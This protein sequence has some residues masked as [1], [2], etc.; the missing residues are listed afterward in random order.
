MF[1]VCLWVLFLVVVPAFQGC[2]ALEFFQGDSEEGAKETA[3]SKEQV[4]KEITRLKNE[5][6]D[7][8]KKVDALKKENEGTRENTLNEIAKAEGKRGVLKEELKNLREEN[9]KIEN[10]NR[11]LKERLEKFEQKGDLRALKIKVLSGDG[12]LDSAKR[13][14]KRL[15]GMDY[16]VRLIGFAP[17]SNFKKNTVYFA[18]K[19]EKEGRALVS[20]LGA[21]TA[22]KPLTWSSVFDLIVVAV[23][24]P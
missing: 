18:P 1:R 19:F 14:S 15:I 9:R 6:I 10:E 22:L 17:R 11:R 21:D 2:G 24:N 5:N 16:E 20:H 12:S 4:S 3:S 23:K 8:K 13:M 7:L